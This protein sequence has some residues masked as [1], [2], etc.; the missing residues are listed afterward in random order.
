MTE[1]K[2]NFDKAIPF[3]LKHEGDY[4]N[5]PDDPGGETNFGITKRDYPHLD[6]KNITREDA[7][8]IYRKVYWFS[9][10]DQLP[11]QIAAK[12][13]DMVVN[14]GRVQ[15]TKL[16]QRAAGVVDDGVFGPKT[17]DALKD[18]PISK[19]INQQVMFYSMLATRRPKLKV[20]LKGWL[21]RANW[22]PPTT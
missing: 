7:I 17:I 3:I 12:V 21:S 10:L 2:S 5:H 20:F 22:T 13:F 8:D 11:F 9:A 15:A 19:I 4:V 14:M 6:I 18:T 16:A 1:E